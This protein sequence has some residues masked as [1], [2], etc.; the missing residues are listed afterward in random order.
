[1]HTFFTNIVV[2]QEVV[3]LNII[4]LEIL[5]GKGDGFPLCDFGSV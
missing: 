4:E 3:R 1:M 5:R 2:F